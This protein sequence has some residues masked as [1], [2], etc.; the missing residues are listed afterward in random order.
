MS[1][2]DRDSENE[3]IE[4]FPLQLPPKR[5]RKCIV[6]TNVAACFDAAQLSDRKSTVLK[7]I[8]CD[9]AEFNVNKSSI[10]HL[11]INAVKRELKT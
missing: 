9:P 1:D 10:R 7:I 4:L 8:G 5:D 11:R 2:S 6:D 3:R